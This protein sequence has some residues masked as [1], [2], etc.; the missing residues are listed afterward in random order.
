MCKE[1]SDTHQA[2]E[3][4]AILSHG[5]DRIVAMKNT[6]AFINPPLLLL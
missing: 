6:L 4:T 2:G 5:N 3:F 1:S